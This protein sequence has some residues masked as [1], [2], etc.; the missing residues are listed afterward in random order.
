MR[1]LRSLDV[2]KKSSLKLI[3]SKGEEKFVFHCRANK[4]PVPVREFKFAN[5]IGR[6]WR[7]DFAWPEYMV[8]LEVEGGIHI[9]GRHNRGSSYEKDLEKYN[10]A[11]LK[12]WLVLRHSTDQVDKGIAVMDAELGLLFRGWKP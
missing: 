6:K 3:G 7:F 10:H 12:G 5:E 2:R 9:A 8:A 1:R 4:L 11:A